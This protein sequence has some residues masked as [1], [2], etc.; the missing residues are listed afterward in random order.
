L[1]LHDGACGCFGGKKNRD[2]RPVDINDYILEETVG[3]G[4]FAVVKKAKNKKNW[5][6]C[7]YQ[8]NRRNQ[9]FISR[10]G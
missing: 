7:G 2:D 5:R 8:N 9:I 3:E 4:T 10:R 6:N 1:L